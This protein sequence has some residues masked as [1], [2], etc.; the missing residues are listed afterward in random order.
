MEMSYT[1]LKWKIVGITLVF[2]LVPFSLLGGWMVVH[3][4]DLYRKQ[5]DSSMRI[6]VE[7]KRNSIDLFL[8]ERIHVLQNIAA[9][10]G[11]AQLSEQNT[12]E[13]VFKSV[14]ANTKSFVDM[15]VIRSD[16]KQVAYVGPYQLR[17]KDY[18][19]EPWFNRVMYREIYI[20]DVFMGFRHFPHF[21]IALKI[22]EKGREWIFRATIDSNIF[23]SLVRSVQLGESGDA[24][25]LNEKYIL[26]TP[27]RHFGNVLDKVDMPSV[28]RFLGSRIRGVSLKG[29]K[30]RAGMAW[31]ENK[32]WLLVIVQ[33]PSEELMP[34]TRSRT[35]FLG[36]ISLGILVILSGAYLAA[37]KLILKLSRA[38]EEKQVLDAQLIQSNKMAALGKLA[39]G[40]AHEINNPL[41]MIREAA[42][43]VKDIVEDGD[44]VSGEDLADCRDAANQIDAHVERAR[45]V[46]HRLL[47]FARR[48]EPKKEK[49][50]L[51]RVVDQT[52]GFFSNEAMHREIQI[53]KRFNPNLPMI[54]SDTS[55][56][57]QVI[58]NILE[59][60]IDAVG[61]NGKIKVMTSILQEEG[62]ICVSITDN[63][64]GISREE[65]QRIFDPFYT[66]KESGEGTGLGLAITYSII[67][68]LGGR[69]EV[70][71][72]VGQGTQFNIYFPYRTAA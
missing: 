19:N 40:V 72:E 36:L 28:S 42:G 65:L 22:S 13:N 2:A 32:D 47:G 67:N 56:L 53:E 15:G 45:N 26:Q 60:A 4:S 69:I 8:K 63:G 58:L 41:T 24:F 25:L 62:E 66:T 34:L 18:E 49:V 35:I 43:L 11:F 3:F 6:L 31:L 21:V 20:S 30:M 44:E 37:R 55:Q 33:D 46:T 23:N 68:K 48:M 50:D 29:K 39:A 16:G 64:K 12:L 61:K 71:S 14:H 70:E 51:N 59:N 7:N 9:L 57:Q 5:V 38:E 54:E 52:V 27:A 17:G 1:R 10:H